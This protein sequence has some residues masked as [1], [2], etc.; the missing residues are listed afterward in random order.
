AVTKLDL[1]GFDTSRVKDMDHM[2]NGCNALETII[3]SET[4]RTTSVTSNSSSMFFGCFKLV[5]GAGSKVENDH[6]DVT[7][8]RIDKGTARK[9][10]F[11]ACVAQPTVEIKP[12]FGGRTVTFKCADSDAEIYYNF[13]SSRITTSCDHVRAGETVFIDEAMWG[14]RA[15]MFFRAH[16]NERWS[17][18]SKWGVLN[19]QLDQPKIVQSGKKTDNKVKIYTQAKDSYIVYTTDGT[20]PSVIEGSNRLIVKNG[21]IIWGTSGVVSVPR[22]RTVRAIAIRCGL[23]TSYVTSYTNVY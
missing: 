14:D 4:F 9:G 18:L 17:E 13:G 10:Y 1:S 19:V 6:L 5:G 22:G 7:Y 15:A 2:F 21:T 8:A 3:V 20:I 11:T 12:V 16:K 23:V